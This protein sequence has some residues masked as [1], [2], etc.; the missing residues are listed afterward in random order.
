MMSSRLY[1][2]SV[3]YL[4]VG[5]LW[6]CHFRNSAP[7]GVVTM[8]LVT[9]SLLNE[10]TR[11]KS[12]GFSQTEALIT[13]H[14]GRSKSRKPHSHDKLRGRS[15][16]SKRVTCY[17]C[18]KIGHVRSECWKYKKEKKMEKAKKKIENKE[19]TSVALDGD[20]ITLFACEGYFNSLSYRNIDWVIDISA[21]YHAIPRRDFFFYHTR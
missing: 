9:N 2:F 14:R 5:R 8:I 18:S 4:T 3:P 20:V 16:S 6:W 13:E 17:H 10:E 11:R 12:L 21:S 19:T 7:D 15:K 1:Y